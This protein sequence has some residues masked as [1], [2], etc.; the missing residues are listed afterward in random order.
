[1]GL[2]G[3]RSWCGGGAVLFAVGCHSPPT[4][5]GVPALPP[6]PW[7]LVRV[8]GV[9][10]SPYRPGLRSAWD[11]PVPQPSDG[12][13]CG[14]LGLVAGLVN[15]VLGKGATYLCRI[16]SRPSQREQD[17]SLPDLTVHVS[18]GGG[19][20]YQTFTAWDSS[21][22][23]FHSEF[24]VPVDAV[25]AEGLSIAVLDRDG[26]KSEL[27]GNVRVRRHQ[28]LATALASP[29]VLVVNDVQGGLQQLELVVTPH[30]AGVED[31]W[32]SV[33]AQRGVTE[34]PLRPLRAG[35][36]VEVFAIGRY[37][38]GT[39]HDQ[40]IDPQGYPGGGPREY[41]FEAE[42]FRSAP[43]G[44]AVA[45]VGLADAKEGAV[46]APCARFVARAGGPLGLGVNDTEPSN[47]EGGLQF[48]VRV[49]SPSPAEWISGRTS[50]CGVR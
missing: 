3:W 17:P 46:V 47:N 1:M 42:P 6:P 9:R 7:L 39:W 41:N 10:V 38:I 20:A 35:E 33:E 37:R 21:Y 31:T 28:L 43:H 29:P 19:A 16:G 23:V 13:E 15:P 26:S 8:E 14:L 24:V 50:P 34:A 4:S 32:A 45:I 22:H 49:R 11:G 36:V 48:L 18:A 25:P 2:G 27:L 30:G 40:W 5:H 12:A 44:S